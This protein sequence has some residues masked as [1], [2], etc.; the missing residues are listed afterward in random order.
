MS[1]CASQ[2]VTGKWLIPTLRASN[3]NAYAQL[4][5][6]Q[7]TQTVAPLSWKL[8]EVQAHATQFKKK[9][10]GLLNNKVENTIMKLLTYKISPTT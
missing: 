3:E 9:Q 4:S 10:N 8:W 6:T 1:S 7:F 2:F 5:A